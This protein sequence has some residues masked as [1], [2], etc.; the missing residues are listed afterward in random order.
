MSDEMNAITPGVKMTARGMT[1][2]EKLHS[3]MVMNGFVPGTSN[4]FDELLFEL[5]WQIRELRNAID[6]QKQVREAD[7]VL[8][9]P[10][11]E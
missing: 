11:P 7:R 10:R 1:E 5:T 2:K 8:H 4:S 9:P 3:W 6:F